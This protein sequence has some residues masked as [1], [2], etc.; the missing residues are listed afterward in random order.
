[1]GVMLSLDRHRPRRG[2]RQAHRVRH[3]GRQAAVRRAG[4]PARGRLLVRLARKVM[5]RRRPPGAGR[6]QA[7]APNWPGGP[8]PH[9]SSPAAG[10]SGGWGHP[11]ARTARRPGRHHAGP[12]AGAPAA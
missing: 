9:L 5:G 10:G 4:A 6:G 2:R 8:N 1:M 12:D 11:A 3:P 7:T